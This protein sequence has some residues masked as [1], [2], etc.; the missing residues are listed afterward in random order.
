MSIFSKTFTPIKDPFI[1]F[2]HSI[3]IPTEAR[4]D[5]LAKS[6]EETKKA[7][8]Q[9]HLNGF[10]VQNFS[11][12]KYEQKSFQIHNKYKVAIAQ[13]CQLCHPKHPPISKTP[14]STSHTLPVGFFFEA[15]AIKKTD[16]FGSPSTEAITEKS[17][18]V[19]SP[20]IPK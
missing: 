6:I 12:Q 15:E 17:Q 4:F 5:R 11:K 16:I 7:S 18:R 8:T 20:T 2:K 13:K 19:S 10:L 9:K 3:Q 1:S 14:L